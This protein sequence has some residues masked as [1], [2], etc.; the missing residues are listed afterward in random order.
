VG[1]IATLDRILEGLERE[2]IDVSD[3][4]IVEAARSLGMNLNAKGSAAFF[5]LRGPAKP[6]LSD[7]FGFDFDDRA[8]LPGK[9]P[10]EE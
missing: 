4:E 10:G 1:L 9:K 2:L 3:E 5:G 8:R 7:F 6:Q